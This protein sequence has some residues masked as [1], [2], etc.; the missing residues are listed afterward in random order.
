MPSDQQ[1][2]KMNKMLELMQ[3]DTLT[4][5]EV[6]GLLTMMLEVIVKAK[7]GFDETS[8]S[9]MKAMNEA[10]QT[11]QNDHADMMQNMSQKAKDTL[12]KCDKMCRDMMAMKPKDGNPGKDGL[13]PDIQTIAWETSKIVEE[14]LT[15]LIPKIEDIENDIPK[16]GEPIRDSLE[17]L[18][19]ENR[20]D[21]S[22]IKGLDDWE[23]IKKLVKNRVDLPSGPGG[24]RG[25]DLT[26]D[27][28][29]YGAVQ[30]LNLIPGS[31]VALSYNTVGG[32]VDVTI[33]ASG[34]AL[35]ILPVTGT[36]ND[37]NLTFTVAS[38]PLLVIINGISYNGT[39]GSITWT[40]LAGT[41][42]LS[43]PVGTGGDI[44]A[45]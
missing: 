33:S 2:E 26:V 9:N 4:P 1:I 25:F 40:W 39:T 8:A 45:I 23:L 32:R 31:G 7:K 3:H 24:A 15:P 44:Y 42:T 20:L 29:H 18:R 6:E 12:M 16:L 36:I 14:K 21:I 34:A 5:K 41:L 30:Y 13:S 35:A 22:A 28:T 19:G 37:T 27:G 43:A 11:M 38:Q 10:V 17:I